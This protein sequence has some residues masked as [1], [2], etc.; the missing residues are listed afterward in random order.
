MPFSSFQVSKGGH[1][2]GTRSFKPSKPAWDMLDEATQAQWRFLFQ[3][4]TI[5][6]QSAVR[7]KKEVNGDA[8]LPADV[9]PD[10]A[11]RGRITRDESGEMVTAWQFGS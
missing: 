2:S 7:F 10:L 5:E 6:R 1:R 3:E 4:R 9:N 11:A 8:H